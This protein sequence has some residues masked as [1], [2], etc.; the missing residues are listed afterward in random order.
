MITHNFI[1]YLFYINSTKTERN[2]WPLKNSCFIFLRVATAVSADT[3]HKSYH[4]YYNKI[5]VK[6]IQIR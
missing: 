6:V 3:L 4:V 2:S 5:L 1:L